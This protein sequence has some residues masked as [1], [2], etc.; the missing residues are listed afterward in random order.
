MLIL[1]RTSATMSS[2]LPPLESI[3]PE[4]HGPAVVA[5]AYVLIV[6]AILFT[7]I[8]VATTFS[9]KRGF[10]FDDAFLALAAVRFCIPIFQ[11]KAERD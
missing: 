2:P 3:S 5:A 9:L 6:V 1:L 4:N 7:T 10:G 11:S 8:R